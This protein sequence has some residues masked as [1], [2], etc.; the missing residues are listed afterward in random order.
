MLTLY[1]QL[2]LTLVV[3][4]RT[5]F[6]RIRKTRTLSAEEW[7]IL[8]RALV[9]VLAARAR[10]S[11]LAFPRVRDWAAAPARKSPCFD[12]PALLA[13]RVGR[14][15]AAA[16]AC[17]PG[18]HTCLVRALA[19]Q[20]VLSRFGLVSELRIGASKSPAG[21]LAAHAWL[22]CMG[23]IVIGGPFYSGRHFAPFHSTERDARPRTGL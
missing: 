20:R 10:L 16:S 2:P 22:E 3:R 1:L 12:D 19:V 9:A 21:Q 4:M 6:A 11:L 23:H 15:V 14:A 13:V 18:G 5:A 17:V 7:I 8:P